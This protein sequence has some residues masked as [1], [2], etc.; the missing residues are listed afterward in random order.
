MYRVGVF[1]W[2]LLGLVWLGGVISIA[3][4]MFRNSKVAKNSQKG[5]VSTKKKIRKIAS[6]NASV[7]NKLVDNFKTQQNTSNSKLKI[8]NNN[9]QC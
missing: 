4:E 8:I 2:I 9:L 7:R 5:I 1:F 6:K 3:T